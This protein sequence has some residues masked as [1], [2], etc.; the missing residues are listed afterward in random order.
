MIGK[1]RKPDECD[2]QAVVVVPS[3]AAR[4]KR[5]DLKRQW[6]GDYYYTAAA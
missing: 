1:D 6:V 3:V 5:A 2:V 4:E